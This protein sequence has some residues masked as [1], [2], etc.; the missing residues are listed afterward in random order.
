MRF[1]FLFF[2]LF[3]FILCGT[4]GYLRY[5]ELQGKP[6]KVTYNKRSFLINDEPSLFISGSVH[7]PRFPE[8]ILI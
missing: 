6:Y 4:T 7:P 8:G 2:I 5:N 1:L 3:P